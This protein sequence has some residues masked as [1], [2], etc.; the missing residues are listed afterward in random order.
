MKIIQIIFGCTLIKTLVF[1]IENPSA[2]VQ[3][4]SYCQFVLRIAHK[5]FL[6]MQKV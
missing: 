4:Y 3:I 5:S 6:S 2:K 1:S